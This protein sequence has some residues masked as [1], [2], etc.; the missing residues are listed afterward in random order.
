MFS[1]HHH[2]PAIIPPSRLISTSR[3][4]RGR[5]ESVRRGLHDSVRSRP[6]LYA[7]F[8]LPFHAFYM[9]FRAGMHLPTLRS[10][11]RIFF[12][13]LSFGVG[14]GIKSGSTLYGYFPF[15]A[16][17]CARWFNCPAPN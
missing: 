14:P 15:R 1:H 8:L 3:L 11:A 2:T 5:R 10:T 16:S 12:M 4:F 9:P 6:P 17:K 7:S 13:L